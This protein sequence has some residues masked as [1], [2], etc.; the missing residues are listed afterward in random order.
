MQIWR[1]PVSHRH[2][3][4]DE[5]KNHQPFQQVHNCAQILKRAHTV[6]ATE[7]NRPC[8][9]ER[10]THPALYYILPL[11]SPTPCWGAGYRCAATFTR[12]THIVVQGRCTVSPIRPLRGTPHI[13]F[14]LNTAWNSTMPP[15]SWRQHWTGPTLWPKQ[16]FST[17]RYL[18]L[19]DR[20]LAFW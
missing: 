17:I 12:A 13:T 19:W 6:N 10:L 3:Q 7:Y 4:P 18:C 20:Q 15:E 8:Y 1:P 9:L 14:L 5:I 2:Q 11:F 16:C